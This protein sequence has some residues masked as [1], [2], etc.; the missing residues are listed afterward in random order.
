[1]TSSLQILDVSRA[2][3]EKEIK[4]AYRKLSLQHHP[5]KGGD[6]AIFQK[7]AKAYNSLTDPIAREN[8][9]KFGNPDGKQTLEV[10]IGIPSALIGDRGRYVFMLA[11]LVVLA[12]GIPYGMHYFWKRN[13]GVKDIGDFDL[14]IGTNKWLAEN[15]RQNP[16]IA[17]KAIPE[18]LAG[19]VES[20]RTP[21]GT[22]M[23]QDDKEEAEALVREFL[24]AGADARNPRMARPTAF[25]QGVIP[26]QLI[27]RNN[28]LL[29]AYLSRKAVQAPANAAALDAVLKKVHKSCEFMWV[30][31]QMFT[32][33]AQK[34]RDRAIAQNNRSAASG[35]RTFIEAMGSI[36]VACAQIT[37]AIYGRD[38][39]LMQVFPA[40][41]VPQLQ[42]VLK[43]ERKARSTALVGIADLI[44]V[45]R[46]QRVSLLA[47]VPSVSQAQARAFAQQ[48][49]ELPAL[50]V[51]A[52]YEVVGEDNIAEGDIITLKVTVT[53]S[54]IVDRPGNGPD[55]PVPP[56]LAPRFPT[57]R[58]EQWVIYLCDTSTSAQRLVAAHPQAWE[59]EKAVETVT[60]MF[61][62]PKAGKMSLSLHVQSMSYVGLDCTIDTV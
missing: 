29:H 8:L 32:Q 18:I 6:A 14:I 55:S 43:L 1:M 15:L 24:G 54:N 13:E 42:D 46:D 26:P 58:P 22:D 53:H 37:Q 49:E 41:L 57:M 19:I 3:T 40:E 33:E 62:A 30:V 52:K 34:A 28:L 4:S 35:I 2:A 21:F 16:D 47:S 5:D 60:L 17:A 31:A 25:N 48:L 39:D 9:E 45:P 20:I 23:Q 56:V 12:V 11:Y 36:P 10:A 44:A 61:M 27:L 38:S 51:E 7:I 50:A 59:P